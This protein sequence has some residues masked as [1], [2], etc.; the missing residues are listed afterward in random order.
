MNRLVNLPFAIMLKTRRMT[1][2]FVHLSRCF[3]ISSHNCHAASSDLA[4]R[5]LAGAYVSFRM[6]LASVFL[7]VLMTN[8]ASP[9]FKGDSTNYLSRCSIW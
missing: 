3:A 4:V 2:V 8:S 6:S 1:G 5:M 7:S 9:A